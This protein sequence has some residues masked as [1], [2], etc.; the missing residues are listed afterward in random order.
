MGQGHRDM[1]HQADDMI[2]DSPLSLLVV[3]S[4]WWWGGWANLLW[5]AA[6]V[7]GHACPDPHAQLVVPDPIGNEGDHTLFA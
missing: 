7:C 1:P 3:L 5:P 6:F 2:A 4:T